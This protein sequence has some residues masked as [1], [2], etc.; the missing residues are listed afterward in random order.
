MNEAIIN[1]GEAAEATWKKIELDLLK[2]DVLDYEAVI[3]TKGREVILDIDV[4]L[5]GGFE[6]G[7]ASTSFS[8]MLP[9]ST[10]FRF[11]VHREDFIDEIG[12]FFGMQDVKIGDEVFDKRMLVRTNDEKT[13]RSVFSDEDVRKTLLSIHN[14]SLGIHTHHVSGVKEP[15][16]ELF[17]EDEAIT[18]IGTL[19]NLFSVFELILNRVEG[20]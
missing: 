18:D 4:D 1:S 12:K 15:F 7:Y 10:E 9:H 3:P 14:F 8:T 11:A 2:E 20:I 19:K 5:G 6:G 17:I 16:L 13:V